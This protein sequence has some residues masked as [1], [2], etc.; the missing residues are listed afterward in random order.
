M[1]RTI[2]VALVA[3]CVSLVVT[4]LGLIF[5]PLAQRRLQQQ[6]AAIDAELA[7]AKLGY[8]RQ[9]AD[10]KARLDDGVA[11][12][13][14]QRDYE[15]DAR[16]KLYAQIEPMLLQLGFAA[17]NCFDR[18][19][20]LA[21][22]TGKGFLDPGPASWLVPNQEGHRHYLDST[23]YRL[24]LPLGFFELVRAKATQLDFK[25]EPRLDALFRVMRQQYRLW[26][27]EFAFAGAAPKL[28]YTPYGPDADA[29]ITSD[30]KRYR[31][32]G[33]ALGRVDK[34]A[35]AMLVP[36]EGGTLRPRRLGEFE[37]EWASE[38]GAL[39]DAARAFYALFEGF[40]PDLMPVFW[41]ILCA[42]GCLAYAVSRLVMPTETRDAIAIVQDFCRD[43]RAH[44]RLALTPDADGAAAA[45]EQ[46]RA[47]EH[48]IVNALRERDPL[49]T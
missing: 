48:V 6:K 43:P 1:D 47:V 46:L 18:V 3:G 4:T 40:R 26:A 5:N 10:L 22:I 20:N 19:A 36:G 2:V 9:L 24:L 29:G 28:P 11:E 21:L 31:R 34:I 13:K 27:A 44:A 8:D 32:Q 41:R 38:K 17:E 25:L 15:Y 30:P 7:Q 16:K 37:T 45:A 49:E 35:A 14:A 12:R 23:L 39:V 42:Q 33:V